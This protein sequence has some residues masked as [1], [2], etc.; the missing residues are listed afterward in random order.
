MDTPSVLLTGLRL[1]KAF[2]NCAPEEYKA[3][4]KSIEKLLESS[5][6]ERPP[7][8]DEVVAL[9]EALTTR[10][11]V[12]AVRELEKLDEAMDAFFDALF[13]FTRNR[14]DISA[15]CCAIGLYRSRINPRS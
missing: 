13:R 1:N 3:F 14:S 10:T 8:K 15:L 7:G 12:G 2:Q 5:S 9:T 11:I 6:L 4:H